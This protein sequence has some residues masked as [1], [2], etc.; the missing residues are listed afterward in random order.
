MT[1]PDDPLA[2]ARAAYARAAAG[3]AADRLV[4]R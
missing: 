3:P 4:A 1:Q 2:Y